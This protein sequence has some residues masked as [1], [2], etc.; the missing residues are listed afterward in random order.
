MCN[1]VAC[2]LHVV[3][4]ASQINDQIACT[5]ELCTW[6]RSSFFTPVFIFFKKFRYFSLIL[7]FYIKGLF[8]R[9]GEMGYRLNSKLPKIL[10]PTE[11]HKAKLLMKLA[12]MPG[13]PAAILLVAPG[14]SVNYVPDVLKISLP[15]PIG[16]LFDK[17]C[18]GLPLNEVLEKCKEL[19]HLVSCSIEQ[20]NAISVLTSKQATSRWWFRYRSGRITASIFRKVLRTKLDKPSVSLIKQICYPEAM[21]FKSEPTE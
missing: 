8:K 10:V 15:K 14:H 12:E 13:A 3:G 17:S 6:N 2:L 9:V 1:H 18:V 4:V 21:A 16:S 11:E 5:E 20:Q 7:L 19:E